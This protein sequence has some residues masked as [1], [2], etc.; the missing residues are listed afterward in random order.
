MV[1]LFINVCPAT[2]PDGFM[3]FSHT[4]CECVVDLRFQNRSYNNMQS[5]KKRFYIDTQKGLVRQFIYKPV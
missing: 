4:F 2:Y 5:Y 1:F 3:V